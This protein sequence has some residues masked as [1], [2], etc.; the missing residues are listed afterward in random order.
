MN[1]YSIDASVYAFPFS[2]KIG[3]AK[4]IENYCKTVMY[5]SRLVGGKNRKELRHIKYFFFGKDIE[6]INNKNKHY[7]FSINT[8]NQMKQILKKNNNN[9]ID[10]HDAQIKFNTLIKR[11]EINNKNYNADIQEIVL[12]EKW[13]NIENINFEPDKVL[14]LPDEV[15]KKI[16]NKELIENTCKNIA[17]IAYL[18]EYVYN[19]N[20]D[21]HNIILN[22]CITEPSISGDDVEFDV[23]MSKGNYTDRN[24]KGQTYNKI[25]KT[26]PSKTVKIKKLK[27]NIS[28]LNTFLNYNYHYNS[29][30]WEKALDDAKKRFKDNVIFGLEVRSGL[31]QYI[32]KVIYER[33]KLSTNSEDIK[34]IDRWM[35]EGPNTL[36]ENLKALDDFLTKTNLNTVPKKNDERYHCCKKCDGKLCP[37]DEEVGFSCK[38]KCE[39][40]EACGSNIRFFG[41]DCSDERWSHK[42]DQS[43]FVE[44][45]RNR[46]N[47]QGDDN[48][49][50]L[51]LKP[52]SKECDDDLWFL[53]LRIHF[54]LLVPYQVQ[55]KIEI[56]WI[57]RHLYLPCRKDQQ[58]GC[59]RPKCPLNRYNPL[60]QPNDPK[61]ELENYL[62]QW[63][64]QE[65]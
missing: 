11:L 13:F 51:H 37:E 57:G 5:I 23:V 3:N 36:Y 42:N 34:K 19:N 2:N 6:L 10:V 18:N 28:T 64:E 56:G 45:D 8:I 46:K 27:V 50:W 16:N 62:K 17:K 41:V 38:G 43:G 58:N 53:T 52:I 49:Y 39:F 7:F 35:K 47:S 48:I 29:Y 40:L 25:I 55:K 32:N 12:F 30:E 33:Y 59:N 65:P 22:D 15:S 4:E 26:A 1:N 24:N 54:R 14:L 21:I 31:R 9:Y 61:K 60:N 20:E 63:P 44:K